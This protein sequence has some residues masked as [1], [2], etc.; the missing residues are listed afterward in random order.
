LL[1]DYASVLIS[2]MSC[3]NSVY[4]KMVYIFFFVMKNYVFNVQSRSLREKLVNLL[5]L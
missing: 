1:I 5:P 4:K 3:D 2:H